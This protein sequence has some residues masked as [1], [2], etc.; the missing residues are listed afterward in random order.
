[1]V[2]RL[3][4]KCNHLMK[5]KKRRKT[6]RLHIICLLQYYENHPFPYSVDFYSVTVQNLKLIN[7]C[8]Q[9]N[10]AIPAVSSSV[11][12]SIWNEAAMGQSLTG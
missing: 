1:M 6:V 5:L 2:G 8:G 7:S 9:N 3:I 11:V 4:Q 10:N 12:R